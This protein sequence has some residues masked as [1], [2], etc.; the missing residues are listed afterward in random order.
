M[1]IRLQPWFTN[2]SFLHAFFFFFSKYSFTRFI[3]DLTSEDYEVAMFLIGYTTKWFINWTHALN[4]YLPWHLFFTFLIIYDICLIFIFILFMTSSID[5]FKM[6]CKK[7]HR[8]GRQ[9]KNYWDKGKIKLKKSN[10][11]RM[12]LDQN[13]CSVVGLRFEH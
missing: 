9:I 7:V 10:W 5:V 2:F 3:W 13:A 4:I 12:A 11:A 1:M 8:L 6:T